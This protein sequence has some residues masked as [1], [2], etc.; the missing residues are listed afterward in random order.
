M[1]GA[2]PDGINTPIPPN[3]DPTN[4]IP[5]PEQHDSNTMVEQQNRMNWKSFP[6]MALSIVPC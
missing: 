1:P 2:R 6:E 3:H 5:M 4:S